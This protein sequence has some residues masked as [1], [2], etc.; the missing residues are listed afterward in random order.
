MEHPKTETTMANRVLL[1]FQ[2][3]N[4]EGPTAAVMGYGQYPVYALQLA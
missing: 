3:C 1:L 4:M 2:G